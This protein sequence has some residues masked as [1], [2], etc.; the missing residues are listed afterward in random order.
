MLKRKVYDELLE[1]K[2]R[3][4][5]CLVISGQR[6]VGKTYIV[7]AFAKAEYKH[8][9]IINFHD[10]PQ[11]ESIFSGDITA[12]EIIRRLTLNFGMDNVVEGETL[13][14][15]DEI[16]DGKRAYS[17]LKQLSIYGKLDV[18]A[19]GSL[20]GVRVPQSDYRTDDGENE[21]LIP[22]GYEEIMVMYP[23]DF[24][25]YLW[26][27][28]VPEDIIAEVKGCIRDRIP[29]DD[30]IYQRLT[31]L[32]RE[33]LI[34]GGMPE[35]VNTFVETLDFRP[36]SKIHAE[37]LSSCIRDI[38][39]YNEGNDR[40]KTA[41]CFDSIPYQLADTN[42]KFMYSRI[43]GGKT[44]K[45]ADKYMENLLWI[46]G[47]GYGV[48]CYG[49]EQPALPLGKYV[50]RD[51]FKVYLSDTGL[52]LNAYGDK[53]RL[54]IYNGDHSY[55]FGAVT[56]N[57]VADCLVKCGKKLFY[58]NNSKGEGKMELD[59]L[60]DFWDGVAVLEVKSGSNRSAASLSKVGNYFQVAR[61]IMIEESNIYVDKNGI[62]HYP[63]FASAFIT[64][65]DSKPDGPSFN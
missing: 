59:F 26:A 5:K 29:I 52:L 10:S 19:S 1:W 43:T 34:V 65:M 9:I 60:L 8:Q 13:V 27:R 22:M 50:K 55:N 17:A 51:V 23:L 36:V 61:K 15:L 56:E 44:R 30:Q 11:M 7:E 35:A 53:A 41:E 24:E 48:F 6:Q 58:Y 28:G 37:L 4:H 38:N 33:F 62:E 49:L 47:A 16:Q 63:I 31:G 64:S 46:K 40:I 21:C 45:S 12:P 3:K 54:A 42:R 25:E 14:F 2:N 18:I 32:F 57:A 20:L 39:R